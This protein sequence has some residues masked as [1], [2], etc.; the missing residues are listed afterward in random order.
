MKSK[1]VKGKRL[2]IIL[3]LT[4]AALLLF[5]ACAPA[6][7]TAEGKTVEV[8]GILPLTGGGGPANQ[9]MMP[10]I[11][12]Y[13]RYFNEQ[14][15]IPGVSIVFRW[16]D[17][18]N[19]YSGV[20][21]NYEK[22]VAHGIH[23]MYLIET[24][25]LYGLEDRFAKDEVVI[26]GT[27]TGFQDMAYAPGWRYFQCP[28]PAEEFAVVAQYFK[29]NWKEAR[30]PRLAFVGI[31]S[32]FGVDVQSE[33]TKYAQSLGFEVLPPET[34]PY[35]VIDATTQLLRLKEEG[36][37]LV[38]LQTIATATVPILRDAE[39]LGLLDQMHIAGTEIGMG[40]SAIQGAGAGSEGY[41][42]PMITP[43]F[44]E[45]EVPGVKLMI[46]LQTKYHGNVG[47]NP[48]YRNGF[49][50]TAVACETIKRAIENV[51]YEN[52]D[53]T[54][55]KE[56]VDSMQDFDVYGL[57]SITYKDRPLDHRGITRVAI[58]EI[59]GGKIVPVTD[60][61]ESPSL[62]PEGLVRE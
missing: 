53:G 37:D 32:Q 56:A 26:L 61:R 21:S 14:E 24:Y 48:S 58:Y 30:P 49:V 25:G 40:E 54:A 1:M 52:L 16:A 42:M 47:K 38:Y 15:G 43:W 12:D 34:V 8:A 19:Q 31:Q 4:L 23:L 5:A 10:G 60:W 6:P 45:T 2:G 41:I 22:F 36:A 20:Y 29:E 55:I 11:F 62:V 33:G 59:K 13:F 51:G 27:A 39:R 46:D 35:I 57:A 18:T 28:T 3:A 44:D 50:M 17:T 7:T 9:E